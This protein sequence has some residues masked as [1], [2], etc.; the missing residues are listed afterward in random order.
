MQC[1]EHVVAQWI[2]N[3]WVQKPENA[4]FLPSENRFFR[5]SRAYVF[6]SA[7]IAILTKMRKWAGIRS[8]SIRLKKCNGDMVIRSKKCNF[9]SAKLRNPGL[10]KNLIRPLRIH[11]R[12]PTMYLGSHIHNIPQT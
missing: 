6:V 1:V 2:A 5:P 8:L 9:Y 12:C 7:K 4:P 10:K 3:L 11:S